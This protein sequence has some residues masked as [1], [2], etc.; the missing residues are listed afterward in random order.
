MQLILVNCLLKQKISEV[1]FC[2]A[3]CCLEFCAL[4]SAISDSVIFTTSFKWDG[5]TLLGIPSSALWFT[6]FF[7]VESQMIVSLMSFIYF[8]FFSGSST[9]IRGLF[10]NV[11]MPKNLKLFSHFLPAS[12]PC[13]SPVLVF[14]LF[15]FLSFTFLLSFS[16]FLFFPFYFLGRVIQVFFVLSLSLLK[17]TRIIS[18]LL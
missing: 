1:C 8:Y 17:V 5:H 12:F 7:Q 2:I 9:L 16:L 6:N 4:N 3:P 15:L 11:L 14:F 10:A 13:L 18:Y